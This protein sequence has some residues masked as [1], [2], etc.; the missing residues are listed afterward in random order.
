MA[1]VRTFAWMLALSLP[2]QLFAQPLSSVAT[3]AASAAIVG[4]ELATPESPHLFAS[5]T[6]VDRIGRIVAPV[7]ING[8]G[9]F[10]LVLD[11]GASHT[12]ISPELAATLGLTEAE[13]TPVMLNG[14]TGAEI[15]SAVTLDRVQAGDLV[16][17]G[18]RAPVVRSDIMAGADGILGVAGLKRER[19]SVDFRK[20]RISISRSR[21]HR[22]AADMLRIP[23]QRVEGGLLMVMA[24]IGGVR[25]R[26]II[27]T[28][29]ER[30]LGNPALLAALGKRGKLYAP[31]L[32]NVF[33]TTAA[34]IQGELR[35]I[36]PVTLGA[37]TISQID[38]VF[39]N[40][41]IFDIWDLNE[42]PAML[43]GMDVL[44]TA[45]QL[46]ID[47]GRAEVYVES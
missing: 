28:G 11:T 46:I 3:P 10:R 38:L 17:E 36:P 41:H 23:A 29:A 32:T 7:M 22:T 34:V 1:R 47:F 8:Q 25:V 30:S 45:R 33:G 5:P 35:A 6:R 18:A 42:G 39:G 31:R 26:A 13:Q 43:I 21:G 15:V 19:I 16:I 9:P 40:F 20:D 4:P 12:T 27:D 14:V 37:A 2:G 44:G 24:Q